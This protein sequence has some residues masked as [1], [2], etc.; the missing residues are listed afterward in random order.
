MGE[1]GKSKL[2]RKFQT[3]YESFIVK[4]RKFVCFTPSGEKSFP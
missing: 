1:Q 2:K 4:S 3:L